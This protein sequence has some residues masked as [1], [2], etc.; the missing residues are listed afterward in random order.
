MPIYEYKCTK[1]GHQFE[2]IQ[3]VKGEEKTVICPLCGDG[4]TEKL[5]SPFSCAGNK[6][7]SPSS[8]FGCSSNSTR[9]T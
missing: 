9:F 5:I 4:H 1:C 8:S 6:E 2:L 7:S 3:P